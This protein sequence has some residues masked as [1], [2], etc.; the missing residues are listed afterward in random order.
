MTRASLA[1]LWGVLPFLL[2]LLVAPAALAQNWGQVEG[3][4]TQRGAGAP[5]PGANVVVAGTDFGTAT[6][7]DG[8]YRLRLPTGRYALRVTAVGFE[9]ITDTVTVR[10]DAT[11][12]LNVALAEAD[13]EL[14]GVE[15]EAQAVSPDAGVYTLDPKTAQRIPSPLSDGLRAIH[16]LPGVATS[17]ETSYQYSVR[18]GGY[19]ENLYFIDGFEVYL[20]FRTRQ[21]E[22]EGLGIVNLDMADRMTLYAGGFPAR[23]GGKLSSAL[24]VQY[25]R[26]RS[27]FAGSAYGSALDAGASLQAGLLD[28][29]LGLAVAGRSAQA[30]SFFGSQELKGTYDPQFADVQGTVTYRLAEGHEIHGLGLWLRHRFRLDPTSRRT[31]FGSFQDLRSVSYGYV[32]QEEDGYDLGFGGIR[33]INQLSE[34]LRVEHDMSLFDVVETETYDI[35]GSV[36]LF[37]IANPQGNPNSPENLI[38]TGAAAQRDE[39]DNRVRVTTLAGSGRYRY[40]VGRHAAE[41]G[42]SARRLEFD[43]RL[44]EASYVSG[45]DSMG[46]PLTVALDSLHDAAKLS[47][48]QL[49]FYVQDA[50]DLLPEEGRLVLTAG[51]RADYF[52]FN[53]EWTVSPRLAATFRYDPM[54]TITASAG[55]YHQAPTYRELRGEP[56]YQ[57]QSGGVIEQTLNHD[58]KSQRSIQ[59]IAGIERFFPSLRFYGRAEAY[60]KKLDHLI[61]Y[62]VENVRTVYSGENDARGY[63]YGFD[64]QLRGEFV[65]GLESWLNYGFLVSREEFLPGFVDALGHNAGVL[66][67]PTDRR[68]NVALFVQDYVPGSRDWKLHLRALFGTG[69]PYTPPV[70]GREIG[71]VQLQVPGD[72]ASARYPEYRRVDMGLTREA[73]LTPNGLSGRPVRLELTGEVLNVFDM[74]N[75]IAYSWVADGQGIWQ[76]IPTRLTPR[77]INVR[78][79]LVF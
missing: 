9:P 25:V 21:G 63:T 35:S 44:F 27:G 61:S 73:E 34:R 46:Q 76:R 52:D 57:G 5:I 66:A 50:V 60:Y 74:T 48:H 42:W 14:G 71:G 55:V 18:G 45:R 58:L 49:G 22:Q 72:R 62:N 41:A 65:P 64:L 8:T 37:R 3:R 69:T 4:V 13:V 53:E 11:T 33:L 39:A 12:R 68:H 10:K 79:R 23:Y 30:R 6:L 32:G 59:V 67:R 19:N 17:T 20:P 78:M 54:T 24:D 26:P 75:T 15:V 77:T 31:T 40:T 51:A 1:P 47:A 29:R 7:E 56:I 28:G 16:V 70:P 43:D 2:A 38:Q 36:S